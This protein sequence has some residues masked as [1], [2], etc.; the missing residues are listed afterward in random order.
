[1]SEDFPCKEE[2]LSRPQAIDE[3]TYLRIKTLRPL[4]NVV[5]PLVDKLI[6]LIDYMRKIR[7][8]YKNRAKRIPRELLGPMIDPDNGLGSLYA[9]LAALAKSFAPGALPGHSDKIRA[10]TFLSMFFMNELSMTLECSSSLEA[11]KRMGGFFNSL[12]DPA[13]STYPPHDYRQ[14]IDAKLMLLIEALRIVSKCF[15]DWERAAELAVTFSKLPEDPL[16]S[17][18]VHEIVGIATEAIASATERTEKKV[19]AMLAIEQKTAKTVKRIDLRASRDTQRKR[20]KVKD[21]QDTCTKYWRLGL[22]NTALKESVNRRLKYED[23]FNWYK[24]DLIAAGVKTAGMFESDI[25]NHSKRISKAKV[26]GE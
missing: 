7:P 15:R 4:D 11:T 25:K 21:R 14:R 17:E 18:D 16:S 22:N 26:K 24:S 6:E 9:N 19:D 1:M 12:S 3:G 10:A 20:D 23:V 2:L 13:N 5:I 8:W